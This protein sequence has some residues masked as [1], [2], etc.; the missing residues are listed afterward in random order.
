[1]PISWKGTLQQ[2]AGRLH[3]LLATKKE[4]RIYDYVDIQVRM[5]E[6]MYQKRLS[7]YALMGYQAKG[8][9]SIGAAPDIIFD[10]DNFLS[11]F[12][13]DIVATQ[14]EIVI[15]SPFVRKHRVSRMIQ[16]LKVATA[17]NLS[18]IVV[19][20]PKEDFPDKDHAALLR[21]LDLLTMSGVKVVFQANIH[22]KFAVMDR[23]IVWYGSINLLSYGSAQESIM[24][25]A[26]PNIANAL[27]KSI[28]PQKQDPRRF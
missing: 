8:G 12:N 17:R 25:I 13:Q 18:V 16:N 22:Q 15:V 9:E 20:R 11:V 26:G 14:K 23:K 10:K 2:Y 24:R 5:L 1:M 3:R 19:T 27:L 4:V 21:T 6:K 28:D 7:G